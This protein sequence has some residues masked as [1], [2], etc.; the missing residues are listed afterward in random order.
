ME[1]GHM[2][3]DGEGEAAKA[4]P[5][6]KN[7]SRCTQKGHLTA[8]CMT[9][10][11]CVLC[12]GHDHVNHKCYLLRQPKSVAHAVGFSMTGMGFYH[13][14]HPPLFRKKDSKTVLVSMVGGKL[15]VQEVATQ[16]QRIVPDR[17]KWEPKAH[18]NDSFV[19]LFPSEMELQWAIAFGSADVRVYGVATGARLNFDESHSEEGG[20]LLPKVWIRVTGL[21]KKLREYLNLWAIGTL[22]G[23]TQMVDMETKRKNNF[24]RVLIAVLDPKLLPPKLD[25]VIGDHY[26]DLKF[27]VEPMGFDENGDEVQW[28][29]KDGED[30]DNQ[31]ME[32]D[33]PNDESKNDKDAKRSRGDN[34]HNEESMDA[35]SSEA[36][37]SDAP[38]PAPSMTPEQ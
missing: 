17:W 31:D 36:P 37:A 38:K 7:C 29:S 20:Y 33:T 12:D 34:A 9:K 10:V 6:T 22:F 4:G 27:E 26:F 3:E 11:Y 24:G 15:S 25:V 23:S 2:M 21:R 19:V 13:I 28:F 18:E 30:N 8:D 5:K 14:P 32:E 16:L 1:W 35:N